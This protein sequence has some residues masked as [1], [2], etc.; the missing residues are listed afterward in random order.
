M[1]YVSINSGYDGATCAKAL[2][3]VGMPPLSDS[4]GVV[5]TSRQVEPMAKSSYGILKQWA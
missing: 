5:T 4:T 3:E 2:Q 1:I